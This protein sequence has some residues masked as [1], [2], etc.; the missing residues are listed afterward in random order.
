M[1]CCKAS[2]KRLEHER[3]LWKKHETLSNVSPHLLSENRSDIEYLFYEATYDYF[4]I[5]QRAKLFFI[6]RVIKRTPLRNFVGCHFS[7]HFA[8]MN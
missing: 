5:I 1:C 3:G 4:L 7:V 2:G 8:S 6:K